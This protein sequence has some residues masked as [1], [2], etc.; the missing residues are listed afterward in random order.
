MS[1]RSWLKESFNRSKKSFTKPLSKCTRLN[2][3]PLEDRWV[4]ASFQAIN[5]QDQINLGQFSIPPDT[6]GAVGPDHFMEVIN[7]SVA[8]FG[9][10]GTRISHVGLDNFFQLTQG[11]TSYPQN[12]AFDP[13]VLY[14]R[15]SGR[16]FATAMERGAIQ[17]QDNGIILAVSR[18]SNPTGA[19]DKYYLDVGIDTVN[20]TTSFTD[21][22]TLAVDEN[23]VYIGMTIFQDNPNDVYA[24]IVA[25]PIAPLLAS[26]PSLGTVTQFSNIDD[27][28]SSPQPAYNFDDIGGSDRA[29]FVSSSNN[30]LSDIRYRTITWS[31]GVPSISATSTLSTAAFGDMTNLDAPAQG[32]T[33]N[34]DTGDQRLQMAV[35]RN[36]R[37][38]TTRTIGV[39]STGGATGA[40]RTGVEWFELNVSAATPTIVQTGRIFDT[41]ATDPRFY[42]YPS[43]IVTGQ[44]HMRVG[45]SGSKSTE[46]IGAYGTGRLAS[47]SLGT[48][49]APP[50]VIKAGERAYTQLDGINRNR[51]GDYSFTSLDPD[52]DMTAWTIQEYASNVNPSQSTWATWVATLDA[53]APTLNNPNASA[54]Q[55]ATAAIINLTGTGL[56]DPGPGFADR[57]SVS[58]S[59]TGIA[60]L[61]TTFVNSTSVTVRFDVAANAPLG[62]RNIVLTNPDGQAVT[63]TNGF[64]VLP[65]SDFG[66]APNTYQTLLAS[67]GARHLG[68]GLTLGAN[69]DLEPDASMPDNGTGDDVTGT[70]DDEDGVA[71]P[72][73]L[74]RGVE[75]SITVN[76]GGAA[77]RLDAWIDYSRNDLFDP[78]ERITD[79]GGTAVVVGNNTIKFTVPVGASTGAT[80]ARFRLSTA[81]GLG[82]TGEAPDGE[83]EDYAVT[84]D[85]ATPV[86]TRANASVSGNEG[87]VITNTGTYIDTDSSDVT[88]TASRGTVTKTGTNSGNWTWTISPADAADGPAGP[89][90][91]TITATDGT[92]TSQITF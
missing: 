84:L 33:T 56:F 19:W 64:A 85:P 30:F 21:F 67:N 16:W 76:V 55:G 10:D 9:L 58:I 36:N 11:G 43:L 25:T 20:A 74:V 82:W 91:V 80:F 88:L 48:V 51:W 13:R 57:L 12:G 68:I 38:W 14:D 42:Y 49:N 54:N 44:G 41:A 72:S 32:S 2:L 45:F 78:A 34:V 53:P 69:R 6:M 90:T 5:M 65:G 86:L 1:L 73:V 31:G 81:G 77:G 63:I 39:N 18:T 71:L 8:I 60:N 47:D 26:T 59:G 29:W 24:K 40:D 89:T 28:Y 15:I 23:G 75:Y 70:P 52:N 61:Q 79:S 92:L 27:M 66:D 4:P 46:F 17:R 87:S 83:V 3:E 22:S 7:S 35:I 62:A 37:L 50:I